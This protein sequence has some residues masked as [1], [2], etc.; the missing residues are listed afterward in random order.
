MKSQSFLG[1]FLV[2]ILL[3]ACFFATAESTTQFAASS[4]DLHN[5]RILLFADMN[6]GN[7]F[8]DVK[9]QFESWNCSVSVIGPTPTVYSCI[10]SGDSQIIN[11]D[12]I[13]DNITATELQTY[14]FLFI[15]SGA[16]WSNQIYKT[17]TLNFIRQAYDLGL[18]VGSM[19][20]GGVILAYVPNL[21]NGVKIICHSYTQ[22]RV[23]NRGAI[24]LNNVSV[25]SDKRIITGDVGG[26]P[27]GGGH[28]TAPY[29]EFAATVV[30]E[31]FQYSFLK[32][33]SVEKVQNI[34]NKSY[35]IQITT[36]SYT[37]LYEN[38]LGVENQTIAYVTLQ[39]YS[40]NSK[41]GNH[42]ISMVKIRENLYEG[43][44][45]ASLSGD[46]S[47]NV[48]IQTDHDELQV[49]RSVF[50]LNTKT[51]SGNLLGITAV[52]ALIGLIWV[53]RRIPNNKRKV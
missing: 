7:N 4:S 12:L 43:F 19:C 41:S 38:L 5:L 13:M 26:G 49:V 44:I 46:Y 42:T 45:N 22:N 11:C 32:N 30:R 52:A 47:V 23:E 53:I 17:E 40:D 16:Y 48:E 18:W 27:Y 14:D 25:V 2:I 35:R 15:P 33:F 1:F 10:S 8:F 21:I 24:F 29:P 6:V 20:I 39:L 28:T 31:L 51:I 3:P 9:S 50:E 36:E 37:S 34:P